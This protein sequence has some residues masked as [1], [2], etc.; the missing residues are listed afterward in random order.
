MNPNCYSSSPQPFLLLPKLPCPNLTPDCALADSLVI[1]MPGP[2]LELNI[3]QTWADV[4]GCDAWMGS[5]WRPNQQ[6]WVGW[7]SPQ[8]LPNW[9][10]PSDDWV[11]IGYERWYQPRRG[12]PKLLEAFYATPNPSA[13]V[14]PC[15]PPDGHW[16]MCWSHSGVLKY[17][18]WTEEVL[19]EDDALYLKGR[20]KTGP[21]GNFFLHQGRDTG[22]TGK[23]KS[24][25]K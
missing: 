23:G 3:M 4:G 12:D 17:S 22:K 19:V 24:K 11:L 18:Y 10:W 1:L 14:H 6:W 25:A 13:H 2:H 21:K 20:G 5:Y 7:H 15:P 9:A 8:N 16:H